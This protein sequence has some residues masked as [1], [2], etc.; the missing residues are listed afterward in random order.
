MSY[1]IKI[2][3]DGID[4]GTAADKDLV[5]SSELHTFKVNSAGS[6]NIITAAGGAI[7]RGTATHN[8]GYTPVYD[9]VL[10]ADVGTSLGGLDLGNG[11]NQS[12]WVP[13]AY[14]LRTGGAENFT[15]TDCLIGTA[16]LEIMAAS[17]NAGTFNFRYLIFW[18]KLSV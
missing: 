4:V 2:S 17:N 13:G 6:I 1:G 8:L 14:T 12:L 18:D 10:V 11:V 9:V 7:K 5:Y 15:R 16:N 3:K